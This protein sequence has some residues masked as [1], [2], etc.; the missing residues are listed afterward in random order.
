MITCIN[1][2]ATLPEHKLSKQKK[3]EFFSETRH[4]FGRTALVLSG[5]KLMIMQYND[6]I[7]WCKYGAIS[8]WCDKM[9]V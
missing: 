5:I 3:L 2:I 4:A 1:Y 8:L 7:R 6:Y 9:F